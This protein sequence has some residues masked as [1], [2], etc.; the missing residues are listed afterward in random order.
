MEQRACVMF[1]MIVNESGYKVVAMVIARV[2]AHL[3]RLTNVFASCLEV[4]RIELD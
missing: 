3:Q 2:A 1:K 4:F